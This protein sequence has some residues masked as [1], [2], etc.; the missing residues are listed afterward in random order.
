MVTERTV[1]FPFVGAILRTKLKYSVI[2]LRSYSSSHWVSSS[3]WPYPFPVHRNRDP[4]P[5]ISHTN[6]A[7][8][9]NPTLYL[10]FDNNVTNPDEK[11]IGWKTL[12]YPTPPFSEG[13]PWHCTTRSLDCGDGA[14]CRIRMRVCKNNESRKI[15]L[16]L[17]SWSIRRL[18]KAM[19]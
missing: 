8:L 11:K 15:V 4:R 9:T 1:N 14:G 13:Q 16:G 5:I 6:C 7:P 19:N 3:F 17:R 2:H 10:I 18:I 12:V